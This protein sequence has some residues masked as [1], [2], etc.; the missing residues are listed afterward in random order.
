MRVLKI[1]AILLS[2]FLLVPELYSCTTAVVSGRYTVDGR[3]L[4]WKHRDTGTEDVKLM[5]FDDGEYAYLGLVNSSDSSGSEVWAGT[6]S[7]GFSIMNS[8]SYNLKDSKTEN[9]DQEGFFMKEALKQCKDLNDFES[10]LKKTSGPRGIEANF[11]VIDAMGGV[12]YYEC[13]DTSYVKYDANDPAHAP[14]GYIIRT[15]YSFNRNVQDGYGYIRY[16]TADKLFYDAVAAGEL[17]APFILTKCDRNLTHSLTGT[18]LTKV[19]MP[20]SGS[21]AQF[22]H[23]EDYINRYSSA[24]STVVHGVRPGENASHTTLWTMPGFPLCS[25]AVPTW[26]IA[27]EDLPKILTAN[28]GSHSPLCDKVV[29]LKRRCFPISRGSGKKY[30][31]QAVLMNQN[32]DGVLQLLPELENSIFQCTAEKM[33]RWRDRGMNVA[34]IKSLYRWIDETVTAAYEEHFGL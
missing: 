16:Q 1:I 7:A 23:F 20:R 29:A 25:V 31:N 14:F 22:V 9:E 26:V 6:N 30:L 13:D 17:S 2:S 28:A 21:A 19:P 10:F 34:E 3:P 27:G 11:G 5:Y 12:A 4:L 15:N 32:G 24:S 33:E 8:A 18:D